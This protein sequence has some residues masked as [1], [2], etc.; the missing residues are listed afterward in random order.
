MHGPE[1]L[2]SIDRIEKLD[3]VARRTYGLDE[4]RPCGIQVNILSGDFGAGPVLKADVK[5]LP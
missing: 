1:I 5:E 2:N 4:I 3:K